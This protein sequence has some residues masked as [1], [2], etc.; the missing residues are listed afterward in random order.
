MPEIVDLFGTTFNFFKQFGLLPAETADVRRLQNV[1]D[2]EESVIKARREQDPYK[3]TFK[4]LLTIL[5]DMDKEG[6]AK[7]VAYYI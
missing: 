2:T 7:N 4:N 1:E 5:L 3:A 6:V